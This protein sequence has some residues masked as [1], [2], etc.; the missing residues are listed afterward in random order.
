[1]SDLPNDARIVPDDALARLIEESDL[2]TIAVEGVIGVGKTALCSMLGETL[3][4][5]VVLEAFEENPF[6][7]DFYRD[8][9][10][11]AFQVQIFF[12]LTRYKQQRNLSQA[13]LFHR[14]VVT[15]YIFEKDKIFAYLNLQD[16][17][18]KL[19]ETLVSSIEHNVLQPDLVVYLQSSVPRL[20]ANIKGRGRPYEAHM[21]ESYIK[22]LNEAYNYYFFRYKATPLLIV[23]ATEID[24]VND[25]D[26]YR[27]LVSQIF[28]PN[29]S[30]VEYYNPIAKR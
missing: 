17:E 15:D 20:M 6:L 11:Y 30:A 28:R 14:F 22:D 18:L 13:D 19:Y 9:E 16:E 10:R 25:N 12:L 7:K 23:N 21:A 8:P 1:M 24:F 26:Q 4:A 29:R 3:N 2:R 27:D 5:R